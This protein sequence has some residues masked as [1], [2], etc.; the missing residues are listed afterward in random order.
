MPFYNLYSFNESVVV[1]S[2]LIVTSID[3]I[4]PRHI[5][6][7]KQQHQLVKSKNIM[8]RAETINKKNLK[9]FLVDSS[10]GCGSCC[11]PSQC[12]VN[13]LVYILIM[14]L[15]YSLESKKFKEKRENTI[16][17]G[18]REPVFRMLFRESTLKF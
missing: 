6:W 14:C 10:R 12:T 18:V 4:V 16:Y 3:R 13:R 5:G 8:R 1:N 15:V 2:L 11:K 17:L 9:I 7:S